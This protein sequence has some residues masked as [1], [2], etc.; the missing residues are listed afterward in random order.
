[1]T[2]LSNW[3]TG[4]P[5]AIGEYNVSNSR[6]PLLRRWWDGIAWSRVY[7]EHAKKKTKLLRRQHHGQPY[8]VLWRGLVDSFKA[9]TP[10]TTR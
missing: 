7:S 8:G 4:T 1:M 2:K 6:D 9:V 10:L 5:P 3:M